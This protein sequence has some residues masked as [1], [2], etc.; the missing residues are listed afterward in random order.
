MILTLSE[1]KLIT[2]RVLQSENASLTEVDHNI[3]LQNE[4]KLNLRF[5]NEVKK[6]FCI[7]ESATRFVNEAGLIHDILGGLGLIKDFLTGA[8]IVK[9]VVVFI[10]KIITLILD[11]LKKLALKYVPEPIRNVSD[12]IA[13]GFADSAKGIV[14]FVKKVY[15]TLSYKGLAKMFA[16]VR[17][18]TWKPTEEQKKCMLA[19]AK[20]VYKYILIFLIVAFIIKMLIIFGPT[21]IAAIKS[22][23]TAA[24][25]TTAFAVFSSSIQTAFA[26]I[27]IKALLVKI[28]STISA[29]LKAKDVKKLDAEIKA[30]TH[31]ELNTTKA[32]F[33]NLW[34]ECPLPK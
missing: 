28:F 30:H 11:K 31:E 8:K 17:Y 22:A 14:N 33:K 1:Q 4:I 16:M 21:I 25:V 9:D 6:G 2:R 34:N 27:G 24:T 5:Y 18:R 26:T 32:T 29:A 19:V 10:E 23:S 3:D 15:G 20:Q 7:S 13:T 12:D